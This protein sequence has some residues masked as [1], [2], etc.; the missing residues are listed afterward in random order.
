MSVGDTTKHHKGSL[1]LE[2]G[3]AELLFC[4]WTGKT[5]NTPTEGNRDVIPDALIKALGC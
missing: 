3:S 5:V 2:N 1:H 4:Y